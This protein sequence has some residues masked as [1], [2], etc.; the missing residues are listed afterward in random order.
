[1]IGHLLGSSNVLYIVMHIIKNNV[2]GYYSKELLQVELYL[3]Y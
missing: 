2:K 1:M 3:F